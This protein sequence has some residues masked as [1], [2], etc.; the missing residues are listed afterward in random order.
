MT[1]SFKYIS[2]NNTLDITYLA[3]ISNLLK[4]ES[5]NLNIFYNNSDYYFIIIFIFLF[6]ILE[7]ILIWNIILF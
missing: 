3:T 2:T 1:L 6:I 7:N 4:Y 5:N